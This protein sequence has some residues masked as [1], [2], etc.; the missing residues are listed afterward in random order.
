MLCSS[1]V[2]SYFRVADGPAGA[3]YDVRITRMGRGDYCKNAIIPM[4]DV[5]RRIAGRPG[6][7]RARCPPRRHESPFPPDC[8]ADPELRLRS[9]PRA[10]CETS[11]RPVV[12]DAHEGRRTHLAGDIR[13]GEGTPRGRCAGVGQEGPEDATAGN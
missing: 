6:S 10:P 2:W 3:P 11:R 7:R 5:D 1:A 8:R 12:G 9:A 4:G 13:Y